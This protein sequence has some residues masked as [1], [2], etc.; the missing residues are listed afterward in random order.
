VPVSQGRRVSWWG[1]GLAG[2]LALAVAGSVVG[3]AGAVPGLAAGAWAA[4]DSEEVTRPDRESAVEAARSSGERVEVLGERSETTTV[5]ANPDG[6]VAVEES[7]VP[8][9]VR[10][11]SEWIPVDPTLVRS[12][13]GW[14]PRV[15]DLAGAEDGWLRVNDNSEVA[16]ESL[17]MEFLL[18]QKSG[19]I[20]AKPVQDDPCR[21]RTVLFVTDG[22]TRLRTG[23][24][25]LDLPI[26]VLDVG[27]DGNHQW[28]VDLA[29]ATGGTYSYVPT[30]GDV[31]GWIDDVTPRRGP[32][33]TGTDTTTDTDGDGL[34]DWIETN[35]FREVRE[36]TSRHSDP[37]LADT[38][39]DGLSDGEEAGDP[40]TAQE[41]GGWPL[42]TPITLYHVRS[43][44]AAPD[45]DGD[46][47]PD[48]EELDLGIDA[49]L[50]D[51]DRD[52]LADG[53]E[54]AWGSNPLTSSD[55]DADGYDDAD[56]AA[57]ADQGHDPTIFGPA[58][59]RARFER[60]AALALLLRRQPG[61]PTGQHRLVGRQPG[62]RVPGL[63]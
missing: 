24:L 58:V 53:A 35:G 46:D 28:L 16:Q 30:A 47:V 14:S 34:T 32:V 36:I 44:P 45:G 25:P 62:L 57:R 48:V 12:A 55:S 38:D 10:R 22:E 5:R 18:R 11:A 50:G 3:S 21:L 52:G 31:A 13:G 56:E 9:R 19:F 20:D 4:A 63:R 51:T 41:L 7:V 60:D 33:Y 26:H 27:N 40:Y 1:R 29:A 17:T 59:E 8:V 54:V 61:L 37:L 43:A 39:G 6:T 42:D 49:L 15:K 23:P 2:C